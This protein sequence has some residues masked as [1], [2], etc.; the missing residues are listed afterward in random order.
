MR[1]D[2]STLVLRTIESG[3]TMVGV[4]YAFDIRDGRALWTLL[5]ANAILG[6]LPED[7]LAVDTTWEP[8]AFARYAPL[9]IAF[10]SLADGTKRRSYGY[11]PDRRS[12]RAK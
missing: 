5:G 11:A 7:E 2:G 6:T 8:G 9:S 4:L 10:V 3:A 1:L 12:L